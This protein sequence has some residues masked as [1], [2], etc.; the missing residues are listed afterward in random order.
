[1]GIQ[2]IDGKGTGG[3]AEVENQK[4]VT[5]DEGLTSFA[6]AALKGDAYVWHTVTYSATAADTIQAVRNTSSTR[7]LHIEKLVLSTNAA[8]IAQVHVVLSSA[9]LAGTLVTGVNL[10]FASGNVAPADA[11]T[12]ET[13][14]SSQGTRITTVDM[15]ADT[16]L[17]IEY[18]GALILD[19]TD[20]VAI[21]YVETTS[22]PDV[23]IFGYFVDK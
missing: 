5:I 10:N 9:A 7:N 2:L 18:N 12:D 22:V 4:L 21:D 14:N 19:T 15:L 23:S 17:V 16:T 3:A 20:A 13:T 8:G 11:R 1:M 6:R